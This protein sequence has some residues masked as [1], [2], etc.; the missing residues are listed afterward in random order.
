MEE[1]SVR[2]LTIALGAALAKEQKVKAYLAA[3]AAYD[4]DAGLTATLSE[5]RAQSAIL[6]EL[7]TSPEGDAE[8]AERVIAHLRAL[9]SAIED[10][11]VYRAVS[12][13]QAEVGALLSEINQTITEYAF[14][15]SASSGGCSHDCAHCSGCSGQEGAE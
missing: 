13:S 2:E 6:R 10:H 7:Q 15:L 8:A 9:E 1:M 3:K 12:E 4:S 11:P 14:G 5:Y